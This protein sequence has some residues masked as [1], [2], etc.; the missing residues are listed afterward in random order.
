MEPSARDGRVAF[1][2]RI[3]LKDV[4]GQEIAYEIV[5]PDDVDS[6]AGRISSASPVGQ[7][8]LGKR[9][10]DMVVLR[11]PTGDLEVTVVSITLSGVVTTPRD[12]VLRPLA[13][14]RWAVASTA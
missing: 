14:A 4:S 3:T 10:G 6:T 8:L 5:G 13:S 9:A 1:G 7:A 12:Q 2:A 11:R